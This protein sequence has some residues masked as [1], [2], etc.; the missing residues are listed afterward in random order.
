MIR[1]YVQPLYLLLGFICLSAVR[2]SNHILFSSPGTVLWLVLFICLTKQAASR[3]EL[4][5]IGSLFTLGYII[6]FW[7]ATGIACLDAVGLGFIGIVVYGVFLGYRKLTANKEQIGWTL[8]FPLLWT[9]GFILFS[10]LQLPSS[11]RIDIWF[12]DLPVLLQS[13]AIIGSYGL[14]FVILWAAALLAHTLN[15]R[16]PI[17]LVLFAALTASLL[18]FGVFRLQSAQEP[19]GQ[20]RIAYTTGPYVGDFQNYSPLDYD[21]A[22]SNV[23][24]SV[25]QAKALNAAVL[26]FNEEAF[27]LDAP[28]AA[29]L[30]Q[31]AQQLARENQLYILLGLDVGHGSKGGREN[32]LVWID[33][34]GIVCGSYLK[35]HL[36][37][38]LET[39]YESGNDTIR[40]YPVTVGAQEVQIAFAICYDSN[41]PA[42]ISQTSLDTDILILPSWD[43]AAI[44]D[45]HR[46]I[47][48]TI[49]VENG[50]YVLKPTYD[51]TTIAADP[52]GRIIARS[53]TAESGFETLHT[54]DVPVTHLKTTS[55]LFG[56]WRTHLASDID[57]TLSTGKES[58]NML[59]SLMAAEVMGILIGTVL[60][61]ASFFE[62][63]TA[64]RRRKIFALLVIAN[65]FANICDLVSWL[66]DGTATLQ[67]LLFISTICSL[68]SSFL[69]YA[70]FY[71]YVLLLVSEQHTP[72]KRYLFFVKLFVAL[73]CLWTIVESLMGGIFTLEHGVYTSGKLYGTYVVINALLML[74][75]VADII[76]CARHL[77]THDF[78]AIFSYLF[79]PACAMILNL[80]IPEYSYEYPA[81]S[82]ALLIIFVMLQ[83]NTEQTLMEQ[84][85]AISKVARQDSLTGL[86][87]HRAFMELFTP[88]ADDSYLGIIFCD[89]NGLKYTND[90]FGHSA[91]D[92]L[93]HDFAQLLLSCYRKD[94]LYRISG[95]EFIVAISNVTEDEFGIRA[96]RL[97]DKLAAMEQPLASIGMAYGSRKDFETLMKRAESE[98]YIEKAQD[99]LRFPAHKRDNES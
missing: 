57:Q 51:G 26:A 91:G 84:E 85:Q 23:T 7:G 96:H 18:L 12:S 44:T 36:I 71:Q 32:K 47:C 73:A 24:A 81:M 13:E 31:H 83:S 45:L 97:R 53:S 33:P 21:R 34:Q 55:R 74:F 59:Y 88:E 60:L 39:D 94:D 79:L 86:Q 87:N 1:K 25:K 52:Y 37:P 63:R 76:H 49:A 61:Y 19:T 64:T 20:I 93:L 99:H 67:P 70:C 14:S 28:N 38:V 5:M 9:C 43:W 78:F 4:F 66:L 68:L 35:E 42:Y 72:G 17:G 50:L 75:I 80:L 6:R 56:N 41:F 3:K 10:L 15:T 62:I 29:R 8:L 27:E 2:F 22:E 40:S 48:E 30:T 46:K 98:M 82:V 11:M 89:V 90:H 92:Q 77:R 58:A 65:L 16:R 69:I 95:D 54:V